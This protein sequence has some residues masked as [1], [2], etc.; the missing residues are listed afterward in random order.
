MSPYVDIHLCRHIKRKRGHAKQKKSEAYI[1][2]HILYIWK[3]GINNTYE[4]YTLFNML[5]THAIET[6]VG[7][8]KYIYRYH[9][10]KTVST[11]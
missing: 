7:N 1:Y 8:Y 10:N 2:I 5:F 9:G 3:L 4:K 11:F 6:Y